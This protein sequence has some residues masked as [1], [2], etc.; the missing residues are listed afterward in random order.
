[1]KPETRKLIAMFRRIRKSWRAEVKGSLRR[2]KAAYQHRSY[3]ITMGR[4]YIAVLV[5]ASA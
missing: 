2:A 1:M 4:R 3:H 5:E